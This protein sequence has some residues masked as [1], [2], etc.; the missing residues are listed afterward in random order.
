MNPL[1]PAK[2]LIV[3]TEIYS[4]LPEVMKL[5]VNGLK[6]VCQSMLGICLEPLGPVTPF[7]P[8][9]LE[10]GSC[11]S[12]TRPG[13]SWNLAL[14]GTTASCKS[15]AR[16]LLSMAPEENIGNE[17]LADALGEILNMIA[18]ITKRKAPPEEAQ[19]IQL[20]LPLFM[21][22]TDCFR[23]L[24]K[25]ITVVCQRV[26]GPELDMEVIIVWQQGQ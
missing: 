2:H 20:G 14:F 6:E 3:E 13:K 16:A 10:S 19:A 25:G 9:G 23:Y 15:L 11:I 24:S 12:L 5:S 7:V 22:G 18:G 17:E 21:T 4:S 8:T 26:A 1:Q